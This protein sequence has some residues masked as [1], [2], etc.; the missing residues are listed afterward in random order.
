MIAMYVKE[1]QTDWDVHL[2]Y[3]MMAYRASEHASTKYT[4]N[5]LML[6]REINLP[7]DILAREEPI[8]SKRTTTDTFALKVQKH[9]RDA[10][11]ESVLKHKPYRGGRNNSMT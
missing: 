10:Y 1:D 2:P 11:N 7:L 9:L 5:F 4:P 6:G 8:Q 3:V